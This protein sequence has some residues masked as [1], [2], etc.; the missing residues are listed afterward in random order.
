MTALRPPQ[1]LIPQNLTDQTRRFIRFDFDRRE[2]H[3]DAN[4]G[5][6]I[7]VRQRVDETPARLAF[8]RVFNLLRLPRAVRRRRQERTVLALQ[9]DGSGSASEFD[10]PVIRR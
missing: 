4:L 5:V 10:I 7:A 6:R 1:L 2:P 9:D 8:E 3:L